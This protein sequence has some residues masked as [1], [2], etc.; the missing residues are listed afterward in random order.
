MKV[1]IDK[2]ECVGCELCVD[3]CP[4]IFEMDE[5]IAVVKKQPG[6]A[7]EEECVILAEE[8]CAV[9]AISHE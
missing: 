9:D 7:E 8:A 3:Q 5:E 1:S 4:D 6:S 2:E